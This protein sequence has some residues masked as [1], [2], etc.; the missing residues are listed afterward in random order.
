MEDVKHLNVEITRLCNQT[1][2]YCFNGSGPGARADELGVDAWGRFLTVQR[3]LGLQS[4]H[5]TGGEPFV[6]GRALDLLSA[7]QTL[8]LRTSVLSNGYKV[9]RLIKEHRSALQRLSVAQISLD[10]ATAAIHDAR[11]GKRGAWR[12]AT[13]AIRAFR[14]AGVACEIS[15]TVSSENVAGV[16]RL[17]AFCWRQGLRLIVRPM[18]ALGRATATK[19][20][21][22][23]KSSLQVVLADLERRYPGVLV[24]DRFCYVPDRP[25]SDKASLLKGIVTVLPDGRFRCGKVSFNHGAG[26]FASVSEMLAA[27]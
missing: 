11:R 10:S 22:V 13:S 17:A 6:D 27:A 4:V 16:P 3:A 21:P 5:V 1:C 8:G 24:E 23:E 20:R 7:A 18:A 26:A 9:E 19:L 25:H 14:R 12:Q 2:S 15:C